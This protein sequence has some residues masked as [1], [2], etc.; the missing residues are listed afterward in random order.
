M[1]ILTLFTV[2]SCTYSHVVWDPL[3][4]DSDTYYSI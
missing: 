4:C 3:G 1:S 2:E